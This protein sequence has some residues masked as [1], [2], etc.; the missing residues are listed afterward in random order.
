MVTSKEVIQVAKF[1][2]NLYFPENESQTRSLFLEGVELD[3][4]DADSAAEEFLRYLADS[5]E[6]SGGG[7]T[8]AEVEVQYSYQGT[9]T[10]YLGEEGGGEDLSDYEDEDALRRAIENGDFADE[11]A[12]AVGED[13][14]QQMDW[15]VE[16]ISVD[17]S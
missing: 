4:D 3:A 11:V 5:I 2:V 13:I 14:R 8:T 9:A 15:E 7:L 6:V 12:E 17:A 16:S 10:V 1:Q